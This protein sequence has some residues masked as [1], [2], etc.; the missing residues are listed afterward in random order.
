MAAPPDPLQLWYDVTR[1]LIGRHGEDLTQRQTAV[2]LSVYLDPDLPTVR[3]LASRLSLG[4]PAVSRALD[5]LEKVDLVRRRPDRR[6][7]RSVVVHRTVRG[8]VFLSDLASLI[9]K[10][11]V[12]APRAAGAPP[13]PVAATVSGAV[14]NT[15]P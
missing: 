3:G 15:K 4:K 1:D 12:A 13:R 6:D 8:S 5:R 14:Q 7:R 2:L 11:A 9:A 10:A